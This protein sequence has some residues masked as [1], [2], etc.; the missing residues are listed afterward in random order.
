MLLATREEVNTHMPRNQHS[1]EAQEPQVA[2]E[3]IAE[4]AGTA[5]EQA[6]AVEPFIEEGEVVAELETGEVTEPTV[7]PEH[8]AERLKD[9][10]KT[11]WTDE[12]KAEF[13][14]LAIEKGSKEKPDY[15]EAMKALWTSDAKT[16]VQELYKTTEVR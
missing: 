2:D 5:I 3:A 11:F 4:I 1:Q 15:A 6:V 8:T 7:V 14:Q 13:K 16:E 9:T 10:L 12:R